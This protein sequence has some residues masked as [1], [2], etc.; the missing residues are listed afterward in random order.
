LKKIYETF[1]AV[2]AQIKQENIRMLEFRAC[3]TRRMVEQF[4]K[5]N[6]WKSLKGSNG[7]EIKFGNMTKIDDM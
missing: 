4:K 3:S 5:N 2:N 6:A 1:S 7:E